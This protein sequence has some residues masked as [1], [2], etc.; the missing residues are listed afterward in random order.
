MTLGK[1]VELFNAINPVAKCAP[2]SEL[3]K[4]MKR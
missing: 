2:L 3:F 1:M 4:A